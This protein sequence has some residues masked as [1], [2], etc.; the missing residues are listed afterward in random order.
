[1]DYEKDFEEMMLDTGYGRIYC[2]HHR[3]TSAGIIMLHGLASSTRTWTRLVG[4]LP[5]ELDL[6][7]VDLLGHGNSDAPEIKYTVNVQV[8]VVRSLV[9]QRRLD[10]VYLF[11]HSYGGWVSAVYA[12][13]YPTKGIVLEDSAGLEEFYNEVKGDESRR[14][15]KEEL[16][17]KALTLDARKHVIESILDD[18]FREGQLEERDLRAITVP[19]L[20]IWGGS[21][22][23]IK[24]KFAEVFHKGIRRS[25]LEVIKSARHTPHYTNSKEVS[26]LLIEFVGRRV[27]QGA[28]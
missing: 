21:D 28:V 8:E 15:Y 26:R 27:D 16:L 10:G 4:Y 25:E 23:V 1:M 13:R 24:T 5:K 18:E 19:T 9:T 3:G 7:L 11:G 17:R 14:R 20:I 2:R 12:K 22:N 6:Y